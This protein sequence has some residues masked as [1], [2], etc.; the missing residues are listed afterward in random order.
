MA[1]SRQKKEEI[2]R[3]IKEKLSKNKLVIFVNYKGLTVPV[4][5]GLRSKL[6]E[7]GI[8]F[9]VIKKTLLGMGLK[10]SGIDADTKSLEGPIGV[11]IGLKDAILP[12]KIINKFAK[13]M[14]N[15]KILSG[16]FENKFAGRD[17]ILALAEVP[18]REEL[19]ARIVGSINSPISGIVN[20]FAGNIRGLVQVLS[21]ISKK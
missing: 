18:S 11:A 7:E 3:D 10:D 20:V 6:R 4:L 5:E 2:L 1:T 19:L 8:D 21:A 13:D 12:A 15:L 9:K 17:K 16:I 14:E